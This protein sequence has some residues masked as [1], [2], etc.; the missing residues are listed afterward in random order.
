MSN[1]ANVLNTLGLV[2]NTGG[3]LMMGYDILSSARGHSIREKEEHGESLKRSSNVTIEQINSL[4]TTVYP[5]ESVAKLV[6]VEER[7]RDAKL[8]ELAAQVREL[9]TQHRLS[10]VNWGLLGV[11]VLAGGFLLQLIAI[12]S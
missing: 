9:Q 1:T 3:S 8:E 10:A 11:L 4:P 7:K 12:Y 5:P 6:A 2:L